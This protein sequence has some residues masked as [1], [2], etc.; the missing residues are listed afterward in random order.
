M[1]S[2]LSTTP[3]PDSL[4]RR[5]TAYRLMDEDAE[6]VVHFL[7]KKPVHTAYLSALIQENGLVS[8]LNR[9][10]FYGSNN[11]LGELQGVA[12]VGHATI[13]EPRNTESLMQLSEAAA[14]HTSTHLVMCEER[15]ADQFHKQYS[16]ARPVA[17]ER[18]KLYLELRW[19]IVQ[20]DTRRPQLRLATTKDIELLAPVHAR[21]ACQ[22]GGVDPRS[23]DREGFLQRYE[24]RIRKGR[25][26]ILV[27][28]DELLF[29]ADVI[30]ANP[31]TC[32]VEGVWVK[33]EARG[34]GF[35]QACVAELAR[36]LLW[37]SR[38]LSLLVDADNK[39]AQLFYKNC[40]FHVR[41]SYRLLFHTK[42]NCK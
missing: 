31:E 22:E 38:S 18:R 2:S 27:E 34:F 15:W 1:Y 23:L 19:P 33:P 16:P 10:T 13:I 35:G 7:P 24:H 20:F 21:L 39:E 26:W 36:M 5:S 9:G 12:L 3:T 8:P 28:K 42:L 29:K 11:L 37:G 17:V 30:A 6:R 40:G 41:G 25:T 4:L 32:Y 14:N